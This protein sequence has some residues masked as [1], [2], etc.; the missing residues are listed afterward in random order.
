MSHTQADSVCRRRSQPSQNAAEMHV[1]TQRQNNGNIN[2]VLLGKTGVGKSSSGN[3]IL[4]ENRFTCKKSL[5]P[6][7]NESRIEKSDTNGRSVSV[8]DTP[9][10][11]CTKLSKEQLA[12]EFARSVKLSAPGVHAFLFVV[13]F[14]RFTE[15]EED[16]LNKVEKVYGKDVLKHLIIL[17]THGDEFDIKDIQSEIAGNEVA[18]RVTQKCRDYH[19][20]NNKDL[21]NRQQVSDLLLKIDSM[22]EM[23]GC[24]TNELYECA[25]IGIFEWFWE[26]FKEHFLAFIDYFRG[27]IKEFIMSMPDAAKQEEKLPLVKMNEPNFQ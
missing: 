10:F 15:Q 21:N 27:K 24:Y 22:V 23:K 1:G 17:F 26:K 8:I 12:K 18:K 6:V 13:P 2:I 19:V 4:G 25:Q 9:G 20:L 14:D 3:T 11:F 16:I 7:T 5:S